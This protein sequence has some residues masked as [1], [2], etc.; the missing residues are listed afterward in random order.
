MAEEDKRERRN[1][2]QRKRSDSQQW[3]PLYFPI[4]LF[5]TNVNALKIKYRRFS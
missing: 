4:F 1:D 2:F 3:A 5:L